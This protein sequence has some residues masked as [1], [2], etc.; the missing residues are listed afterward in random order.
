[1]PDE[2][3]DKFK[4]AN[5]MNDDDFYVA[6]NNWFSYVHVLNGVIQPNDIV[7]ED[8][9]SEMSAQQLKEDMEELWNYFNMRGGS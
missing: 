1:M 9:L 3:L 2:L 8:Y 4:K 5:Y 7:C 6:N